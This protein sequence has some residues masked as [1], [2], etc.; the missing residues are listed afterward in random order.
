MTYAQLA[1]PGATPYPSLKLTYRRIVW[2]AYRG[3]SILCSRPWEMYLVRSCVPS[4]SIG[5]PFFHTLKRPRV[6]NSSS[7]RVVRIMVSSDSKVW[8]TVDYT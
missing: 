6:I 5:R 4:E 2:D 3:G 1:Q 7:D 8:T